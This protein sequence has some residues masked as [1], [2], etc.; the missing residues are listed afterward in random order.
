[1]C[2]GHRRN[3]PQVQTPWLLRIHD[4]QVV[5][6]SRSPKPLSRRLLLHTISRS[7]VGVTSQ[8]D[9][10]SGT[11]TMSLGRDKASGGV[12]PA[13]TSASLL[14]SVGQFRQRHECTQVLHFDTA[15]TR[16]PLGSKA[17]LRRGEQSLIGEQL[18]ISRPALRRANT[19]SLVARDVPV[20]FLA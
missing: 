12:R 10:T 4:V 17:A 13:W 6:V 20:S 9:R 1:M 5:N 18:S 8:V 11:L 7:P 16:Q 14:D 19:A 3:Q 2:V 15:Q